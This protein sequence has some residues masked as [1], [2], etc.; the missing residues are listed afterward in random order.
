MKHPRNDPW[1][2]RRRRLEHS[3]ADH[4]LRSRHHRV[5]LHG[6]GGLHIVDLRTRL[7][8]RPAQR[9]LEHIKTTPE[10]ERSEVRKI[11]VAEGFSGELLDRVVDTITGNRD[12]CLRR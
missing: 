8:Q 5:H 9:E 10:A 12:S 1:R 3:G 11:Y 6:R 4:R 7:L 2:H